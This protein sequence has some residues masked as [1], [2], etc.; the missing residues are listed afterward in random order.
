MIYAPSFQWTKL[1]LHQ[2]SISLWRAIHPKGR[3]GLW[4]GDQWVFTRVLFPYPEVALALSHN[5]YPN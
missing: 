5:P 1:G 4:I 2:E 3:T